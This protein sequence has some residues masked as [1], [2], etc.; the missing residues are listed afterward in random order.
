MLRKL[1]VAGLVVLIL[2]G[3]YLIVVNNSNEIDEKIDDVGG[4]LEDVQESQEFIKV[5]E[6]AKEKTKDY[7]DKSK[8]WIKEKIKEKLEV[9]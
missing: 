8:D 9:K 2:S 4:T 5:K 6:Y 1:A 3:L 7:S